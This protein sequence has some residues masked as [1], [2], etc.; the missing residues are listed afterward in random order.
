MPNGFVKL[1]PQGEKDG[2]QFFVE[3]VGLLSGRLTGADLLREILV[4]LFPLFGNA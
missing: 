4:P 2:V 1:P 3:G